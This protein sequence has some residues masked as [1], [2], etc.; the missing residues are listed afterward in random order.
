MLICTSAESH[1]FRLLVR[2]NLPDQE[3]HIQLHDHHLESDFTISFSLR[4]D[5]ILLFFQDVNLKLRF[6]YFSDL[7]GDVLSSA[8]AELWPRWGHHL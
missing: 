1:I 2:I 3:N 5:V 6:L 7:G 8:C 4:L